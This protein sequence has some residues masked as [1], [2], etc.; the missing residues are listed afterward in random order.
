MNRSKLSRVESV[1]FA[2][3]AM[4]L[5]ASALFSQ[6]VTT[7]VGGDHGDGGT[8]TKASLD[9]PFSLAKDASGNL[10]VSEFYGHR[11]RKVTPAGTISTYA[12]TGIA[13]YNGDG[14]AANTA[15]LYYPSGIAFDPA[16][17]LIVADGGNNRVRKID[18]SGTI[19][20]IAGTGV[21]GYT[22]DGG[23]ALSATFNQPWGI[24]YDS[25]GNLYITDIGNCVVR[26]V[27][28]AGIIHTFAGNGICSYGGDGGP[29]TSASLTYPRGMVANGGNLY[30]ADTDNYRVRKVNAAGTISTFAGNGTNGFT[31]DG[32]LATAA[33]IARPR[34]LAFHNQ[35]LYISNAGHQ[36]VRDVVLST[37][38]INTFAG[39]SYGYDGDNNAL[40]SSEFAGLAGLLFDST[41]ALLIADGANNRVRKTSSG[42]MKTIAGGYIGDT[43]TASAASVGGPEALAFD[44]SGA[45]YIAEANGNRIRKVSAAGTITTI[46]GTGV[47]GYSGDGGSGTL[48]QLSYPL[49]VA[50]D[51]GGNVYIADDFNAVIRKVDTLGNISTFATDPNFSGL[52]VIATDSSNNLYV[53]DQGTCVIWKVTPAAVVSVYAGVEFSCGYNGD[54]ISALTAQL[55]IPVGVALDSRGNVYIADYGNNRVRKVTA[56]G[57]ISTLAGDGNCGFTGDGGLGTSAELCSPEGV[58][59]TSTG[60][61]YIADTNN[62]RIRKLA[63]GIITT[64]AG[65]GISGFNGDVSALAAN[66]DDPVAVTV[67][68]SNTLYMLDDVTERVRKIH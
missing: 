10:Y 35:T 13:G 41:G 60:A 8:A 44:Q 49:G 50:V 1:M 42:V 23:P 28:P 29:A 39:S 33:E 56:S 65:T 37:G 15:M 64:Y 52:G 32:G 67:N 3:A 30:I 57:I 20:T 14:I 27:N 66:F 12:G 36:R 25:A 40:L 59:V 62:L 31:G 21:V 9:F 38:I 19:T 53:V 55:N 63:A 68:S 5:M 51:S 24:T 47:N 11:I 18:T 26:I 48:A 7:V 43:K 61:I 46:A 34:A 4:L 58:A 6:T 45:Y 17:N 54:N 16:G 2:F 22:G